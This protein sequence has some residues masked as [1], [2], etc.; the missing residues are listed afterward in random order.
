MS[1]CSTPRAA[2]LTRGITIIGKILSFSQFLFVYLFLDYEAHIL[3]INI[4]CQKS[5]LFF[6]F[7]TTLSFHA[8]SRLNIAILLSPAFAQRT[9][10]REASGSRPFFFFFN[11]FFIAT[12]SIDTHIV[13]Y[14]Y[15]KI[16]SHKK[17]Y[18]I[19]D[20]KSRDSTFY[21]SYILLME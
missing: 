20:F 13:V 2:E 15:S 9:T 7:N 19:F 17:S 21:A 18:K 11:N 8:I 16:K 10:E 4:G 5:N 3:N 1:S 14:T 6:F 12:T